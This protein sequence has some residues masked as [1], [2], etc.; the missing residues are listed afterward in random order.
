[1]I[2]ILHKIFWHS[3]PKWHLRYLTNVSTEIT[4]IYIIEVI[5]HFL[6][7]IKHRTHIIH[8][9]NKIIHAHLL[10]YTRFYKDFYR[11]LEDVME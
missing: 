3:I 10:N 8:H 4:Q 1:M 5:L 11:I 7:F 9:L 2:Y 6:L